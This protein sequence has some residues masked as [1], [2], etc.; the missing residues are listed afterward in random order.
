MNA[1]CKSA[2]MGAHLQTEQ[3]EAEAEA[4]AE[5]EVEAGEQR[6]C[7]GEGLNEPQKLLIV[8]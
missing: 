5:V 7:Y 8:S 2:V 1:W 4:E 6:N 3:A